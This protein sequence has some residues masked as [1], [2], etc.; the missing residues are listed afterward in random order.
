MNV[1]EV[2]HIA[3]PPSPAPS[4]AREPGDDWR[5]VAQAKSGCSAAFG[6]LYERHRVKVYRTILRVLRHREDAEDALQ[7]SFQRAFT[8]LARFRGDSRFSTWVTR[9]AINEALM[10]L[11][12]RRAN[13]KLSHTDYE[14]A[15]DSFALNLPDASPTPEQAVAA[16]ELS[17]A[18]FQAISDLRNSLRIVVLLRELQGLTDEETAQ[19]LGLTVPAV[20]AR[21]FRARRWLR[22]S[23]EGKIKPAGNRPLIDM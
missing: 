7:R 23:L 9:I 19:R 12:H 3:R 4:E 8:N 11:R 6:K 17:S 5:L 14:S 21:V 16:N 10:L 18:L 15:D 20:K 22:R 1:E 13:T 2:L